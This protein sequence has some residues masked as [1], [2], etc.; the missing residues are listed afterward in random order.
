[1]QLIKTNPL[2]NFRIEVAADS[3]VQLDEQQN[4]RDRVEFLQAMGGFLTQAL[5]MGQQ[6][7]DLIPMLVEM[8]KFGV[9]AYK[10]ADPIEGVID[11]AMDKMKQAAQQPKEPQ[12]DPEMIKAQMEQQREQ[13]R[14]QADV[15]IAETKAQADA[16]L[17]KQKQDFEAWKVQF[18]AQN[19]VNLAR[20]KANPGVDV[21]LLEAQEL[22]SKQ[23]VQQLSAS[24]NEALMRMSQLHEGMMQMQAQ[25]IN[26]IDGVKNMV[27][28]PKRVIRGADGKVAG[29]EVV[30]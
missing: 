16:M 2:R 6:S 24:L 15:Q 3:L 21:P 9:S 27:A 5:P 19:Q 7:P 28:A 8:V 25:T 20:I 1:L 23:M 18:E 26:Q 17:E 14:V 10:Q 22:Q 29:V 11:A 12:P 13:S 4:K 30:Q